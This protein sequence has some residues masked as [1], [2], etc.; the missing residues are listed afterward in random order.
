VPPSECWQGLGARKRHGQKIG[1][2]LC[3]QAN[4]GKV[5]IGERRGRQAAAQFVD[6]LAVGQRAALGH[7]A[8]HARAGHRVD[9]QRD[10]A[11]VEQQ[12][13]SGLHVL[14]QGH[15]GTAH[16]TVVAGVGG[17]RR[18][19][20]EGLA[21]VQLDR[22]MGEAFNPNLRALQIA[23]D[24]DISTQPQ[25]D[26]ARVADALGVVFSLAVRKVDAKHVDA[27][28][29]QSFDHTACVGGGP[30]GGDDLGFSV[31][32]RLALARRLV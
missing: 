28:T 4:V 25:R 1:I 31:H 12:G 22:A 30:H 23:E 6:A 17:Q 29:N 11:V 16:F 8:G 27:R 9:A 10:G 15:V 32:A 20:R 5:F 13:V 2:P 19:E 26:L 3:R 24:A 14:R 18:V 7:G 21:V